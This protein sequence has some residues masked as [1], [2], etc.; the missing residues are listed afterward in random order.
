[1]DK[2]N[3]NNDNLKGFW[4]FQEVHDYL[5]KTGQIPHD[6][7]DIDY[8]KESEIFKAIMPKLNLKQQS[9]ILTSTPNGKKGFYWD[10]VDSGGK[11]A[12]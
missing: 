5:L 2:T 10:M 3:L 1:M 4:S 8:I 9:I 11:N 6:E 12:E 7:F